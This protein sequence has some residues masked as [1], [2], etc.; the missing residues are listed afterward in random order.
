[1][2]RTVDLR[3]DTP[4]SRCSFSRRVCTRSNRRSEWASSDMRVATCSGTAR[5]IITGL[6]TRASSSSLSSGGD[7]AFDMDPFLRLLLPLSVDSDGDVG[8]PS[9]SHRASCSRMAASSATANSS[10]C[11]SSSLSELGRT[12]VDK[13]LVA[14]VTAD[15]GSGTPPRTLRGVSPPMVDDII[16]AV[17]ASIRGVTHTVVWHDDKQDHGVE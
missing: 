9:A 13:V 16:E 14:T 2:S 6:V 5:V 8:G 10:S 4:D 1:M 17:S 15:H 11:R 3:V 7:C 12:S